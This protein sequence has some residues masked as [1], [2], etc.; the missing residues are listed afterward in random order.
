MK[1]VAFKGLAPIELDGVTGVV[2]RGDGGTPI[3]A[4]A[5]ENASGW[6]TVKHCGEAGFEDLLSRL[7]VDRWK[8]E[9][10][11]L[12]GPTAGSLA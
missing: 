11:E 10:R 8:V 4:V 6:Y 9:M 7:G 1:L 3:L 2:V 5:V 12:R